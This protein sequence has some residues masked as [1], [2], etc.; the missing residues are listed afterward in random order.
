MTSAD[1]VTAIAV[2]LEDA[3]VL[4]DP[5]LVGGRAADDVRDVDARAAPRAVHR[6]AE[7]ASR[8]ALRVGRRAEANQGQCDGERDPARHA[9]SSS[10]RRSPRPLGHENP[11]ATKSRGTKRRGALSTVVGGAPRCQAREPSPCR[12]LVFRMKP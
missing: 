2:D 9:E 6:D 5:D 11:G 3:V 1:A 7:P 10:T 12:W 4:V 8:L